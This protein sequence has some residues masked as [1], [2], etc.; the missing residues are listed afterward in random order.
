MTIYDIK[1]SNLETLLNTFSEE[2]INS[3]RQKLVQENIDASGTLGNTLNYII[4]AQ[5]GIYEVSLRIQ[6]Y[7]K[8]VEEGRS[9]G[10]FPPPN[11]IRDWIQIKPVLPNAF[12]GVLPTLNQLGYL[13]GRKIATEGIEGKHILESTLNETNIEE[14]I[15]EAI[16]KDMNAQFNLIFK[17]F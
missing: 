11:V 12:N 5:D 9:P 2:V 1:F 8:Y 10:K 6:D 13:I 3:Y 16:T 17:G 4:E 7:W 15:D 14:R